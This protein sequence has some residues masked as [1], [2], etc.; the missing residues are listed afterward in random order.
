M[1]PSHDSG[2]SRPKTEYTTKSFCSEKHTQN[3]PDT[4]RDVADQPSSQGKRT[5]PGAFSVLFGDTQEKIYVS[6]QFC[7]GKGVFL[8]LSCQFVLNVEIDRPGLLPVDQ[9]LGLP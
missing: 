7:V 6:S 3:L 1:R 5:D 4:C 9:I 2:W 8:R